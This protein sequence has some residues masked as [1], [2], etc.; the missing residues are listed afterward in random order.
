MYPRAI[1]RVN[2]QITGVSKY[3]LRKIRK[4][5][6]TWREYIYILYIYI[7]SFQEE[8]KKKREKKMKKELKAKTKLIFR[9]IA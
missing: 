5:Y 8:R 3:F 7:F 4:S 6:N 9:N 2:T 1:H